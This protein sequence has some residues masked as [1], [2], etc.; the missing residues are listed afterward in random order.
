MQ[1]NSNE[2]RRYLEAGLR[3]KRLVAVPFVICFGIAFYIALTRPPIYKSSTTILVEP[4]QVPENYV[5]STVTGSVQDRLNTI[6]QQIL[7]RTR[8]EAIIRELNLYPELKGMS[9][10]TIVQ[11]MQKNIKIDLERGRER[12]GTAA[13]QISYFGTD[14][15]VVQGVTSK[16]ASLYIEENLRVRGTLAR[17]TKEFLEKQLQGIEQELKVREAALKEYKEKYMGELPDQ[18]EINLRNVEQLQ[19]QRSSLM[20]ALRDA[21]GR[22]VLLEQQLAQMPRTGAGPGPVDLFRQLDAKRQELAALKARYTDQ[23]PDV[24]RV[25]KEVETLERTLASLQTGEPA[26]RTASVSVMDPAYAQIKSQADANRLTVR[27]L[28]AQLAEADAKMARLQ[29]RLDK[30]PEREQQ[31]MT[32]TRDYES[33]RRS[34]EEM[35]QRRINAEISENLE[36]RQKSEQFRVLD[37]ANYP[38]KAEEPKR[39]KIL[40]FGLMVGLGLGGVLAFAAEYMDRSFRFVDDVKASFSVPVLGVVPVLT[41]SEEL[42][43]RKLRASALTSFSFGFMVALIVGAHL[44]VKGFDELVMQFVQMFM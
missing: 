33:I 4:Q 19:T 14:P 26:A 38:W 37:P 20:D 41:T 25:G 8:L 44:F 39:I 36:N 12:G 17:E 3:R 11:S 10:D 43:K 7:S 31:Y 40:A 28:R 35:A 29:K 24:V 6:S 1:S 5:Q 2:L 30:V 42:R 15:V 32:L 21:E 22:Q 27:N 13:F 34:Y 23:Y 18:L 9:M 16:L